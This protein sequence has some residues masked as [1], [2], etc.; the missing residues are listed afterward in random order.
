M[1]ERLS[2][3]D[4]ETFVAQRLEDWRVPGL[5][6]GILDGDRTEERGFG[7]AHAETRCAV[8]P[9]TLFQIGSITKVYTATLA[10]QLVEEGKLDLDT[11]VIQYLPDLELADRDAQ[12]TITMRHL[13]T[14]TSGLEGDYFA[15]F[16]WGDDALAEYVASLRSLRQWTR[17]GQLWSYCNSGF[18]LAGRVIEVLLERPYEQAVKERI[19]EPLGMNHSTFFAHEAITFPV[20][21]GHAYDP[22]TGEGPTIARPYP[23]PR[24]S[25]P[26]GG[27][28]STVGDLLRFAALHL[29]G[30]TVGEQRLLSAAAVE[31]MRQPHVRAANFAD[32]Y[33]I[34]W[35]L[36]M[37][38]GHRLV[39]HGG[40]TNGFQAQ[41]LL[42][43][44]QR[45]AL[46]ILTNSSRGTAAIRAIEEWIL[47]RACGIVLERPATVSLA[48]AELERVTGRYRRPGV[49]QVVRVVEDGIAV[50]SRMR[51]P[52]TGEETTLPPILAR[53]ISAREYLVT[54]GDY[55]GMRIDFIDGEAGH[56]AFMR[57]GGRLAER[58]EEEETG[59]SAGDGA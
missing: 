23:I 56:P 15:D 43:P 10:M 1:A 17:P 45:F 40:S 49:E 48:A 57:F 8:R 13:L 22:T 27:I 6:I 47:A 26:A 51:H 7:I 30:G 25:N 14:H 37:P 38:G 36:R 2:M 35:A 5:T 4:L 3:R 41:L 39:E 42:V 34:G 9:D 52:L 16:G 21:V 20:S 59:A 12:L 54:E 46:A 31:A 28:I 19:F 29:D 58:V 24:S 11:P 53:P 32:A 55:A 44:E 33:G 50:E 18:N